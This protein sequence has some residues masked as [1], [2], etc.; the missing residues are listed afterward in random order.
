MRHHVP[1]AYMHGHIQAYNI[2]RQTDNQTCPRAGRQ[3]CRKTG[4]SKNVGRGGALF[5]TMTFNRMVVGST[6]ALAATGAP[7][8]D[9]RQV[10]YLQLPVRFGVK[11]RYSIRAV[12]G[13][14]PE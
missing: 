8:R 4:G 11:L 12:V 10:P 13:S 1:Q 9:L 3:T 6:P 7:R 5:E 14:A 2:Y